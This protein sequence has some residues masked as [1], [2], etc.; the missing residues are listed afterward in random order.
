[1]VNEIPACGIALIKQFEGCELTAYPDP[2][3]GAEPW[4]IGWGST[5]DEQGKPFKQ[6]DK[7]TR[8]RADELLTLQLQAVYMPG[9]SKIPYFAEMSPEQVGALLSFAYNLGPA[10]YGNP[11]FATI[12]RK[13]LNKDWDTVPDALLLYRNVG[14]PAEAGLRARREAEGKLWA[15]GSS[16]DKKLITAKVDTLLKKAPLQS[17][18]LSPT[19]RKDVKRGQSYTVVSMTNEGAHSKVVLDYS[20]GTW[21]IYNPHWDI[22]TPGQPKASSSDLNVRYFSQRDSST[23]YAERMCFS[24]SC[25]MLAEYMKPGVLGKGD[26][27]DDIY[28]TKYVWKYGDSTNY[29]AQLKALA[30]LG[31]TAEY[32]QN[33]TVDDVIAQLNKN[34]PVPVGFLHHGMVNAP[35]GGGHWILITGVDLQAKTWTVN[36]PYGDCDLVHGSYYGSTNGAHLTYSWKNFNPRWLLDSSGKYKDGNGWGIMA[37]GCVS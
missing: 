31:I 1:M 30:D 18:E 7:I 12:S 6:G 33:L 5:R 16:T 24:S 37:S 28:M 14:S 17:A 11:N 35:T 34:I 20:A 22:G 27:L 4:T 26:N 32:R 21:Y 15:S 29:V 19:D 36:D 8:E 25:A 3:T 13:L 23:G 10:F 2:A 9:I